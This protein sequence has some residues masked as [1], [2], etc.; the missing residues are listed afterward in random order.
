MAIR[1]NHTRN[2]LELWIFLLGSGAQT[3]FQVTRVPRRHPNKDALSEGVRPAP[4]ALPTCPPHLRVQGRGRRLIGAHWGR[5]HVLPHPAG[6]RASPHR[7]TSTRAGGCARR[8][9][10][11]MLGGARGCFPRSAGSKTGRPRR[12]KRSAVAFP[13]PGRPSPPGRVA[14]LRPAL[15]S[16]GP[17]AWLFIGPEVGS[18]ALASRDPAPSLQLPKHFPPGPARSG[19]PPSQG[20]TLGGAFPASQP[21]GARFRLPSHSAYVQPAHCLRSDPPFRRYAPPPLCACV[22]QS[23]GGSGRA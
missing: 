3:H 1:N 18:D 16:T 13:C 5:C 17:V 22:R 4:T 10:R 12:E 8:R 6:G 20:R 11:G 23:R 21:L 15:G 2:Q 14:H 9:M 7:P 19:P